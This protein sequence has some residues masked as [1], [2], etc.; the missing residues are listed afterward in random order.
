MEGIKDL[1]DIERLNFLK[2]IQLGCATTSEFHEYVDKYKGDLTLE[3]VLKRIEGLFL[4]DEFLLLTKVMGSGLFIN[5]IDQ[6]I[7]LNHKNNF[8]VPDFLA[9]FQIN[10]STYDN[11][12]NGLK[13]NTLIEVK[14][15]HSDETKKVSKTFIGKYSSFAQNYNLPLLF[16]SRLNLNNTP[17]WIIQTEDQ[18]LESDRF[19]SPKSMSNSIGHL[20]LNDVFY[21]SVQDI[22]IDSIYTDK[23]SSLNVYSAIFG[24]LHSITISIGNNRIK[25]DADSKY[26]YSFLNCYTGYQVLDKYKVNGKLLVRSFIPKHSM[27][28]LSA[29]ILKANY[30]LL[31]FDGSKYSS[32]SRFLSSINSGNTRYIDRALYHEALDF[33]NDV[34]PTFIVTH[35]GDDNKY[36]IETLKSL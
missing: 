20:M 11:S 29:M 22:F 36:N 30:T 6:S 27:G 19:A 15:S 35:I 1:T 32:A 13:F 4:E 14:T 21:F 28:L 23:P 7:T 8:K 33:F 9:S 31:G 34:T 5:S 12:L 2:T 18:L 24:H 25:L 17:M 3:D 16:A 10:E 26:L